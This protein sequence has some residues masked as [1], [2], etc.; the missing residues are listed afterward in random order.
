MY[1]YTP[2]LLGVP[3]DTWFI[4]H[5]SNILKPLGWHNWSTGHGRSSEAD[6]RKP[7]R[8]PKKPAVFVSSVPFHAN[9]TPNF[10]LQ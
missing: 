1:I 8:I 10:T 6:P 5:I 9:Q 4:T 7:F 2:L 3:G